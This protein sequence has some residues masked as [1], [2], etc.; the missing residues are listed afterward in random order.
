VLILFA[1]LLNAI[2]PGSGNKLIAEGETLFNKDETLDRID[3]SLTREIVFE[4]PKTDLLSKL[5]G[6]PDTTEIKRQVGIKDLYRPFTYTSMGYDEEYARN[7][8][9]ENLII[10]A[11]ARALKPTGRLNVDDIKRAY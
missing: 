9:R 5:P 6:V 8:V 11:L 3:D 10:Y 1:S 7:K 2:N 4:V